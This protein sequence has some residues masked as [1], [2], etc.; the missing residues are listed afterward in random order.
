MAGIFI[1]VDTASKQFDKEN[2][3]EGAEDSHEREKSLSIAE[4]MH[5]IV[6]ISVARHMQS[7]SETDLSSALE[8]LLRE[9]IA[10]VVAASPELNN[11]NI[12]RERVCYTEPVDIVLK[13]HEVSLRALFTVTAA[14]PDVKSKKVGPLLQFATWYALIRELRLLDIDVTERD[15]SLCFAASRM[16]VALPYSRRGFLTTTGVRVGARTAFNTPAH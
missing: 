7:G 15:V 4:F 1:A 9:D 6:R 8:K 16:G 11:Y 10:P 13:K 12:F 14:P 5:A 3:K 2:A